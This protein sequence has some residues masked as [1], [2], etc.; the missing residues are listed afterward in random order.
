MKS[1][2]LESTPQPGAS[3]NEDGTL[4]VVIIRPCH[5]R[6]F[7]GRIYTPDMLRENA[8]VFSGF[9]MFDNH[10]LPKDRQAR[11]GLPRRP[12]ELAG[13]IEESWWD[14]EFSTPEDGRMGFERGAVVGRARLTEAMESLVRRLP[15]AVKLSVNAKATKI[16]AG[17]RNGR[18]GAIVE[19]I[20]ADPEF[21]S[22]DLVTT[23]GA[24][25]GVQIIESAEPVADVVGPGVTARALV[26][27]GF[28]APGV[29][30]GPAGEQ[31]HEPADVV[32]RPEL[33]PRWD[34]D[35]VRLREVSSADAAYWDRVLSECVA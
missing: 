3:F 29:L 4:N 24:G 2:I 18:R 9:P 14:P 21:S 15:R 35:G 19:G 28:G 8:H 33:R 23:A 32:G 10:E 12:S 1:L 27:A 7:G 5:G 30:T 25:G 17:V 34:S 31:P 13:Q 11:G 20:E 22:V 26:E 6:G 16:R